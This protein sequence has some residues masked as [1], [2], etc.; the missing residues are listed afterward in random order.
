MIIERRFPV[1]TMLRW[2]SRSVALSALWC[3]V[4]YVLYA[5]LGLS[6]LR[7]PFL[8]IAT[9]GTAV[10]F[11]VGF[12]NNAAYDRFWEGRKIWGGVVN[13]SRTWATMVLAYVH[14][15]PSAPSDV[16]REH[17]DALRREL[18]YRHLAW[19][20][21][22]RLQLR[23]TSRFFDNPTKWT[24]ERMAA[25]ADHMRN[26][27]DKELTPF[28]SAEELAYVSARANPATHLLSKQTEAL[29]ALRAD[30]HLD[31]FHQIEMMGL[32]R[33]LYD[34]Q[35]RCERIKNTPLP[36]Q[37]AEFSRT[38]VRVFAFLVPFGL[39]DVFATRITEATA[40]SGLVAQWLPVLPMIG[41][42][43][44]VTWVFM[45]MEGIGDASEDPFERSM[46]D[47]P[48]NALSRT[49]E[50]DLRELL[51]ETELPPK[52]TKIGNLMY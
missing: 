21:A 44:L 8:P 26:D 32:V 45:A 31:L 51:G 15:S 13:A 4:V 50:I 10:A 40:A 42:S 9:V 41:A 47:V 22:L 20:N 1:T 46:N 30:R 28:L 2:A 34:L 25:H 16:P 24:R 43:S 7:V 35:G 6:V 29:A 17:V 27:W 3:A 39:L 12:K 38:F 52:E 49:I 14:S 33:E 36:R 11:Y 37:Y 23:K 18:V 19:V 48:M 5:K